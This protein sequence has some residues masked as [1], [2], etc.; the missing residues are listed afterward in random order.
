MRNLLGGSAAVLLGLAAFFVFAGWWVLI[1]TNIA[2]LNYGDR[3]MHTLGWFFY[4]D[5]PWAVPPGAS[6]DLGLELA[7]SVAIADGLPL[8]AIPFKLLAPWLPHPF[9]YWGYWWLAC[10]VLQSLF[11]YGFARQLGASRAVALFAAGFALITPAFL[12]RVSLHMALAGHWTILAALYLY[13]RRIPP[14]LWAW[15]L[16][17]ALTAA[18]HAYLFAICLGLWVAAYVQRLWLRRLPARNSV[19]EPILLASLSGVVLWTGGFFVI[20]SIGIPGFGFYR[21]NPLWPV[22]TY[23]VWSKLIPSLPHGLYDYEGLGWLGIG[24]FAALLV[25]TVTGALARLT[26]LATP[27]WLPLMVMTLAMAIFALSNVI[28]PL[29]LQAPPLPLN[30]LWEIAGNTLRSSGRFV[31]PLLYIVTIGA[32]VLAASRLGPRLSVPLLAVALAAQVADSSGGW[33]L[34][35]STMPSPSSTWSTPLVSPFWARVPVA[36]YTRIRAIPVA[37]Y[38]AKDWQA[39]ETYAYVQH[40]QTDAVYLGRLDEAAREA[41]IRA[42]ETALTTGSFELKTLYI[43]DEASARRAARQ[44]APKDLLTL[45]DGRYVFARNGAQLVDGLSLPPQVSFTG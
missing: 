12:F 34:F 17:L 16:L 3:A 33:S 7:S 43:L 44:L 32:V 19:A 40:M 5:G 39:L 6:P 11:T 13:A 8:F 14:P 25:A 24:I 18:I 38:R 21:L 31:W 20:S 26:R 30:P 15:P 41:L 22:I 4:R 10:F 27:R 45:V 29:D 2:W 23:D 42:D 1:P 35:R 28:G 36:G 9:Q 37:A